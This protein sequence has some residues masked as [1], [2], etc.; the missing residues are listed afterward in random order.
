MT[1]YMYTYIDGLRNLIVT[2]VK[3]IGKLL[4]SGTKKMKVLFRNMSIK[5]A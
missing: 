2:I 1:I 5:M 3:N 4:F